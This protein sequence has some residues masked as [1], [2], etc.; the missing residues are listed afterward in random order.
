MV[1]LD[2]VIAADTARGTLV[3]TKAVTAGEL[4]FQGMAPGL[5]ADRYA[6]PVSLL[7]ES[8]GQAAAVL[9]R[10]VVA[11]GG[12][13]AAEP[14]ELLMFTVARDC[15]I[16][17]PVYP[18]DILRHEVELD[19]VLG[20]NAFATGASYVGDRRV[21]RMGSFMAVR[22]AAAQVLPGRTPTGPDQ[23][24]RPHEDA[25]GTRR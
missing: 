19:N 2:R 9:W 25:G 10:L 12:T 7:L 14:D 24:G 22:R 3:A 17:G 1:L 23:A 11:A 18:G 8:F 5:P 16:E 13:T 15:A 21:A 4:C 20:A 6:Y